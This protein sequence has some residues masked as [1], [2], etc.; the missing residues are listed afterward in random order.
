MEYALA[1]AGAA[2]APSRHDR[3]FNVAEDIPDGR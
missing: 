2:N 1:A 3:G